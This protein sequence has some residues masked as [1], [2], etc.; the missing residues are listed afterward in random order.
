MAKT[1]IGKA[2]SPPQAE[3]FDEMMSLLGANTS[4]VIEA[5][6]ILLCEHY[7]REWPVSGKPGGWRLTPEQRN[8]A[9]TLLSDVVGAEDKFLPIDKDGHQAGF[10]P[11]ADQMQA[12]RWAMKLGWIELARDGG[13]SAT[14]EGRDRL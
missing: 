8:A 9:E 13:I 1:T 6:I 2:I 11:Y 5:A 12:V 3:V 4:G 14:N 7:G 10:R